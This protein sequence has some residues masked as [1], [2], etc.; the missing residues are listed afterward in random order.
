MTLLESQM[1]L[2]AARQELVRLDAETGKA[3]AELEMLTA[4]TFLAADA[5]DGAAR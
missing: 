4:T 3:W 5:A 1:A 2:I